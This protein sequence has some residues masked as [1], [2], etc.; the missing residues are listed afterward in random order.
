M[1]PTE[2][3]AKSGGDKE[4]TKPTKKAKEPKNRG[5]YR[6]ARCGQPKRGH[7]CPF[8]PDG[9]HGL[10]AAPLYLRSPGATHAP[11]YYSGQGAHSEEALRLSMMRGGAGA[12]GSGAPRARGG[13]MVQGATATRALSFSDEEFVRLY[14]H[15]MEAL[16]ERLEILEEREYEGKPGRMPSL[17]KGSRVR[18]KG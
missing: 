2:K 13:L 14:K 17:I 3:S 7:K 4:K 10:R 18:V 11:S 12:G 5:P 6:C 8:D 16:N 15:F 9:Y 1:A